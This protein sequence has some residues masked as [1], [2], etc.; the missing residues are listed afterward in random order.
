MVAQE[1]QGS[2][3][4]EVR[5]KSRCHVCHHTPGWRK[6]V[7]MGVGSWQVRDFRL[8]SNNHVLKRILQPY[9]QILYSVIFQKSEYLYRGG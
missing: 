6:D 2:V 1:A 9:F 5:E 4:W 7:G 8:K 3:I